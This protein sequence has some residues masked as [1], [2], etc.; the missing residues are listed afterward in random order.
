VR[1]SIPKT[2]WH[3]T[4]VHESVIVPPRTFLVKPPEMAPAAISTIGGAR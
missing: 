1:A 2:H 4:M 3:F